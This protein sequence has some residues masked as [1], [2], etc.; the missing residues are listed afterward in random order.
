MRCRKLIVKSAS[1]LGAYRLGV[2][3]ASV[4]RLIPLRP[5]AGKGKGLVK[6]CN[7]AKWLLY[8]PCNQII[9]VNHIFTLPCVPVS[10]AYE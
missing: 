9:V 4:A 7:E 8:L 10:M 1:P 6:A 5:T 2:P 3:G